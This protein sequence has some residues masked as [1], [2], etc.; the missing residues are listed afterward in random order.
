ME[1]KGLTDRLSS[2]RDGTPDI[3]A[4]QWKRAAGGEEEGVIILD[5][6]GPTLSRHAQ[7]TYA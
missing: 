4:R 5:R 7:H 6:P 2:A 3:S 1:L